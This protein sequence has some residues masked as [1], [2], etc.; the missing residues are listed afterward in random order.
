[1]V[2]LRPPGGDD[3]VMKL[4]RQWKVGKAVT[5]HVA[6]FLPPVA[7]LDPAEAV[8]NSFNARPG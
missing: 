4:A 8:R 1:M 5:V 2:R 7:I 3:L 6:H